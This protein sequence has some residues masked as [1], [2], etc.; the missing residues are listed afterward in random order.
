MCERVLACVYVYVFAR[1]CVECVV[2][3]CTHVCVYVLARVCVVCVCERVLA[4]VYVY[5]C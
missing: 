3:A 4:R 1:V 5:M 2:C